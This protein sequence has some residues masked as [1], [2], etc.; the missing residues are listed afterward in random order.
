METPGG[1]CRIPRSSKSFG[2]G[3][4]ERACSRVFVRPRS[5]RGESGA[6][7]TRA[8]SWASAIVDIV[9]DKVML[10]HKERL[11][12]MRKDE[13]MRLGFMLCVRL[14]GGA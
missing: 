7:S 12:R 13:S 5:L 10:L 3:R 2:S 1:A 6:V 4:L 8:S 9:K 11:L 14:K